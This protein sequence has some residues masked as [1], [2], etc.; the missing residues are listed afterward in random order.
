MIST[1]VFT[2]TRPEQDWLRVFTVRF[3]EPQRDT[4]E[5]RVSVT[6]V[7]LGTQPANSEISAAS[8]ERWVDTARTWE[9]FK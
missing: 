6:G 2:V 8:A 9:A 5:R 1:A 3:S 7:D 4:G